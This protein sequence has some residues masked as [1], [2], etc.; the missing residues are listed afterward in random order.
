MENVHHLD[1]QP[2][3]PLTIFSF[4]N[5][6]GRALPF[7]FIFIL[8]KTFI[9]LYGAGGLRGESTVNLASE[10]KSRCLHKPI[11]RCEAVKG[12]PP[13]L[14]FH[15]YTYIELG[16]KK[17]SLLL[18]QELPERKKSPILHHLKRGRAP[19]C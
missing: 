3:S 15:I 2:P 13:L 1:F 12:K 11:M 4:E 10:A 19:L 16:R 7:Y 14:E 18:Q 9:F 17:N 5:V 6:V 8:K